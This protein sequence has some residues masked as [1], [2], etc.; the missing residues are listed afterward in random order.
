M[1][2]PS[3]SMIPEC[4]FRALEK[5]D[6]LTLVELLAMLDKDY[7]V[8]VDVGQLDRCKTVSDIFNLVNE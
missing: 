4:E 2:V 1:D 5:W 3:E 7:G 8:T 6:S